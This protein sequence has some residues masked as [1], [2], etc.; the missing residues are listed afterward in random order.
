VGGVGGGG[1][2]FLLQDTS[3][4][5]FKMSL[6]GGRGWGVG[7]YGWPIDTTA[8][9][10]SLQKSEKRGKIEEG[11]RDTSQLGRSIYTEVAVQDRR[12]LIAYSGARW[13]CM[14]RSRNQGVGDTEEIT[15][16]QFPGTATS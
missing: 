9:G 2:G 6:G 16:S 8:P 7:G 11:G 1:W 5:L 3:R 10:S 4:P 13:R 12:Q 15:R 14:D